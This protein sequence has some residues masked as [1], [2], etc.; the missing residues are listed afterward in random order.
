MRLEWLEPDRRLRVHA[1]AKINL[2]LEVLGERRDGYHEIDSL[3]LAVSLCDTLEIERV[4]GGSVE[5]DV[6]PAFAGGPGGL[7]A[8]PVEGNLVLAAVEALRRRADAAGRSPAGGLRLRLEKRIPLGAG[9]GGGSSDAAATLVALDGLWGLGLPLDE[10]EGAAAELG[11]DV[12]FFLHGGLARCRG[13]GEIVEPVRVGGGGADAA[14]EGFHAVLVSPAVAV[15]T[16]SVYKKLRELRGVGRGLTTQTPFTTMPPESLLERLREGHL[17]ANRLQEVA[18]LLFPDLRRLKEFL[19]AE[20][21][22]AVQLTGS[23]S[24][25]F[26]LCRSASHAERIAGSLR[27]RL[28]AWEPSRTLGRVLVH[29]VRGIPGW[30]AGRPRR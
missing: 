25:L 23:G 21:F 10:L 12:A 16:P 20:P 3:F 30:S 15:P 11:S 7:E 2:I 9:L 28:P 17:L 26:G 5:L 27:T 19:E 29:A 8:P 6:V 1:P 24:T 18:F 13:R 14:I 4:D 22:L